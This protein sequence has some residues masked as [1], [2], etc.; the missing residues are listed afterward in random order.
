VYLYV[1]VDVKLS[2]QIDTSKNQVSQLFNL[3]NELNEQR[4]FSYLNNVY[5]L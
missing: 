2:A 3:N 4:K 5:Y 1:P